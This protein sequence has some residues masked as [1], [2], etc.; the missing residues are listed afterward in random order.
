M[1]PAWQWLNRYM[2]HAMAS[3]ARLL[4]LLRSLW[5]GYGIPGRS[6]RLRRF[7]RTFLPVGAL[8]FDLGAHVGNRVRCWRQLGTRVVAVEPQPDCLAVLRWLYGSDDGVHIVPAAVDAVAGEAELWLSERTPTVTTLSDDWLRQVAASRSFSKV[9]WRPGPRV[10]VTTLDA[11]IA[12]YGRPAFVKIDVEGL[13][14]RVLAGLSQPLLAL[15]FEY[16]PAV[17]ATALACVDRLEQLGDYQYNWSV[18]EQLRLGASEWLTVAAIRAYLQGLP[19]D[20][21]SGDIYARLLR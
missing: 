11:L 21:R 17:R 6:A 1:L 9:R 13:E 20:A 8:A 7:Y 14:A 12:S 4:G 3:P 18:G 16:I 10:P 2:K 19:A 15:S 5:L